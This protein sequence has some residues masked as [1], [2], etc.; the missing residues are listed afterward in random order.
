MQVGKQ[1]NAKDKKS[2]NCHLDDCLKKMGLF[3][4]MTWQ[5]KIGYRRRWIK[6]P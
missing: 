4:K 3:V 2:H 1:L 5:I 6:N